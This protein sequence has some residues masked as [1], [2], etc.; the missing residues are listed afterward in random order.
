MFEPFVLRF[1]GFSQA[2]P[3]KQA[4]FLASNVVSGLLPKRKRNPQQLPRQDD[5]RLGSREPS[6]FKP[7]IIRLPSGC[8]GDR[9]CAVI[10]QVP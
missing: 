7:N 5:Q 6:C 9:L 3:L 10:Q 8:F 2:K 4:I 1:Y